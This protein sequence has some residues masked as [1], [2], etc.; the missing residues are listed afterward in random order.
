MGKFGLF[1]NVAADGIPCMTSLSVFTPP[2]IP[3]IEAEALRVNAA[4]VWQKTGSISLQLARNV[5]ASAL[6]FPRQDH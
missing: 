6:A 4:G 1:S 5:P 3:L 2:I